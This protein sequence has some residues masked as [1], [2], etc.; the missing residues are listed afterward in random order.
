M[1]TTPNSSEHLQH[2]PCLNCGS[3]DAGSRYSDGHFFCHKCRHYEPGDSNSPSQYTMPTAKNVE[4]KG[5]PVRLQKRRIKAETCSKFQVYKDEEL[6]RF[7]YH[8]SSG[9]IIAAKVRNPQKDFWWEG[10]NSDHRLFGQQL[11]SSNGKS[12]EKYT[13][14]VIITEGELDCL[15]VYEA[16]PTMWPVVSLPDGAPS[17]KR[18]CQKQ[19]QWLQSFDAVVLFFDNDEEGKEAAEA[20]AAILPTG[21]AKIAKL[22]PKYKDASDALQANDV[23]AIKK[24]IWKAEVWSPA[25]IVSWDQL[26]T[27]ITTPNAPSVYDYPFVGLNEVLHGVRYGELITTTA[28]SGI[29]KSSLYRQFAAHFLD[30]GESVGYIALEESNKRT[31]LGIM[32]PALGEAFHVG[33]RSAEEL[34]AAYDKTAHWKLN[35]FDGFGSYDPDIIYNR[36]EY[37]AL[38]LDVRLVFLDHL[39]ILLSGLDGDER[40]TIDITMTRLRSLV[41]RT[42]I[43]LFLI[44]HLSGSGDGGSY[45]EGGRV[46]LTN[47]RGSKSIGQL[48][49]TVIALERDQQ[50]KSSDTV[51]R[52]LKNRYTGETGP[53]TLLRWNR[54]TCRYEEIESLHTNEDSGYSVSNV[55]AT[56]MG[57]E[58]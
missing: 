56:L 30:K 37:M 25:G 52:V 40:R 39:S 11:W 49:D 44:C 15:S 22:D 35:M 13:H 17:A 14:Q 4:V 5:S 1:K 42:G 27:T 58:F 38:G 53:A 9:S 41:E 36:I 32:A 33:K 21:K 43:S 50:D 55:T 57:E 23:E 24:A 2:E 45:E 51:C 47:L 7:Y 28:G 6:L 46:K 29:G 34:K 8:G 54:N 10:I 12:T 18:A 31:G 19:L 48:S 20:V 16:F 3:S 26:I